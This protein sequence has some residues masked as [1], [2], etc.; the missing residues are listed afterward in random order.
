LKCK[1]CN[2]K[3]ISIAKDVEE[4]GDDEFKCNNCGA[5]AKEVFGHGLSWKEGKGEIKKCAF[6]KILKDGNAIIHYLDGTEENIPRFL[7]IKDY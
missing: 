3:M 2:E 7:I 1:Y 5:K 6:I 4:Y